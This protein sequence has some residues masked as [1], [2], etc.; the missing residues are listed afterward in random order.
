MIHQY[1][2]N[3]FYIVL[4]VNSGSV[5][6]VDPLL[7][8]TIKLLSGRLA[9]M[10]EP[11]PVPRK[12][13]EEVAELLKEKYS[14]DEIQ[15]AFSDIQELIDREELF[16][17]DIYKDYVMDFKKRQTVVKALC[18]HIAH[19]CN[20]A[21]R[22]C[23]A[24]E[25]EYHGRR[26]LM[27]YEVGKKALDFLIANSGARRNLEVD[28][29]GGEPLMNWEVVKQL[30]EY[31]RSQEEL[32]NKKFRF[33]L[34]TNGVLLNDEIM[35]FSNREMS[36]VVLSLDGRQDVNDRMRPFRNGRGSYDL[37]VPKFQKFAKE[38]GDRDYFVR[39]TFTRN[40]LDFA[41]DVL[42]FADLGFE[43]MSVEPVVASPE[44]PYAIREEDL[45]QIMEEYDRLAEEYIKRHKEGRGFT[46]FHFMLDLNQG[47]CVAKRLSGCG[48]GTE[49]L[50]VTPWGD[51]YPCHQFVGNE[52]FLLGNVDEG[53]TKTE[54]C[55]EFKLCN[56]YAKDKC[57]D[58]FAR[59]YCSGGC[60]ANSFNF[61][62]SIT[63]A[64]D[65]GCEMQK[66][67]IECAI[68]IKAA[69]AEEE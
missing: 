14:A 48:S 46:F 16:T 39:G 50:A 13:A 6:S 47:P 22:Y 15:E 8:D 21:C 53:V 42:H 52:E 7:Y 65:I 12:T 17:A 36:N 64:Y 27:S 37:I 26:A 3:G 5:H 61:H 25:G 57:R 49:Y 10:K 63:D 33:T 51:L 1:I 41:D 23:F 67:R 69:L 59:F 2:N 29:F 31:G 60:A 38:R 58:C 19:D 24:E 32:H 45:P 9:D 18:L 35:E 20:L 68:M 43:K 11:A 62:G 66:K 30:V 34:T 56:V 54:I 44:E 40:N 28:F 55:N 4:D